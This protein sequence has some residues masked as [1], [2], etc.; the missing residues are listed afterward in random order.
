MKNQFTL[1]FLILLSSLY[2]Q[3]T[4]IVGGQLF[5][6]ENRNSMYNYRMGLTMYF[7]SRN[8]NPAAED[9]VV[10]IYIFRKRDNVPVAYFQ[11]PKI[12]RKL[13]SYTNPSCVISDLQTYSIT[14]ALDAIVNTESFSDPQGYYMTWDRCCRNG[15]I[16]NI[17]DPGDAGSLFYL[18]FPALS[19]NNV[20]FNNSSPVFPLIE[21]DYACINTPFN[22]NFGGTDA[23]G[24]SLVYTLITPMQGFSTK[25]QPSAPGR[26][27]SNFPRLTFV[28]GISI[29]N[30]IPGP[31]PLTVNSRTGMLSVTPGATGLY[32]FAVQVDEY[33]NKVRIGSLTR[34]FQLKVVDCPKMEAPTVLYRP[35]GKNILY[36]ENEIITLTKNDPN[37]FEVMV[38]DPSLNDKIRVYGSAVNNTRDYFSL[39]P[40]E[41][42]TTTS[43]DTMRFEVCLDDCFVTYGNRPIRLELV[44]EDAS[45]PTPLTDTL[46]IYIRRENSNNNPPA[47]TTSL[48]SDY[49]NVTAGEPVNF[50]VYGK[51][52][53]KDELE[54]YARG[55]GFALTSQGMRFQ[56]ASGKETVQQNFSWTPPCHARKGDTLAV[57]FILEDM[58]CEGN[59]L[60]V[61]RPVY[62]IVQE[63]PN[64][65]PSISTDLSSQNISYHIGKSGTIQFNVT[66][67]DVDTNAISLT[68][69]G[70]GFDLHDAG[71]AFDNISGTRSLTSPYSW[72][73]ECRVMQ[74]ENSRV[75]LIDFI[76]QDKNCASATD[77]TT[78][79]LTV[80]TD[81]T[82]EMPEIPNVITPNNDGKNDCLVLR[83]LPVGNCDNQFKQIVVYN[84]WGKQVYFTNQPGQDWCPTDLNA[85]QYYYLIEYTAKTFKGGL[86]IIK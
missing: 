54:L 8:G 35:A 13:V 42:A 31:K 63:S 66:A 34:D 11:A 82:F 17:K 3:A 20:K 84:R 33:R 70:R 83:N 58:R 37:C 56:K 64:T 76:A 74:G 32:V 4:H 61:S 81:D 72:S 77:T 24:D 16:T 46:T 78:V 44:A 71:M 47:I 1:L 28:D 40:A 25:E 59:P 38:V 36:K 49:V 39:L 51:D 57:D 22:F 79:E 27:S 18:E 45:C 26:G 53:D 69:T 29:S 75:F 55:A 62:F 19:R 14:Y 9:S 5:I 23:D 50:T 52:I 30:V 68:A 12:E 41:F 7:D 2:A 10:V 80:I 73:P 43:K 15:T 21:G 6:T 85:G 65:P 60:P 86:T 48:P 67:M